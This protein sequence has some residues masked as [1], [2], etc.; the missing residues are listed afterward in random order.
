[1]GILPFQL[2]KKSFFCEKY[3]GNDFRRAFCLNVIDKKIFGERGVHLIYIHP[4]NMQIFDILV[5]KINFTFIRVPYGKGDLWY[6]VS[7]P[8]EGK[9]VSFR[10]SED[11]NNT[12]TFF[13]VK[14]R[15][16]LD[17]Q[18]EFNQAID[19][20]ENSLMLPQEDVVQDIKAA[21]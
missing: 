10:M 18:F 3:A 7:F 5:K 1:L 17:L 21:S 6:H 19:K 9:R 16:I 15:W 20:F 12:W 4:L 14:E 11:L 8:R 13:D 2:L